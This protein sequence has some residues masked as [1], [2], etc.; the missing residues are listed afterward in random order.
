MRRS[1]GQWLKSGRLQLEAPLGEGAFGE[2]W[3][4]VEYIGFGQGGELVRLREAAVKCLPPL[5]D[6]KEGPRVVQEAQGL[7]ELQHESILRLYDAFSDSEGAYLI[8]ELA[9]EGHLWEYFGGSIPSENEL[10]ELLFAVARGL[11]YLHERGYIHGDLKPEN[12][13]VSAGPDYQPRFLIADFGLRA[14]IGSQRFQGTAPYI[15]PEAYRGEDRAFTDRSD[16][17]ALGI[18]LYEIA[19]G[20]RAADQLS[21]DEFNALR[22]KNPDPIKLQNALERLHNAAND[23]NWKSLQLPAF[24]APLLNFCLDPDPNRRPSAWG[25]MELWAAFSR[26]QS[27]AVQI[28]RRRT[29]ARPATYKA[30]FAKIIDIERNVDN[31]YGAETIAAKLAGEDGETIAVHI[32]RSVNLPMF[33][34]VERLQER[35]PE[36]PPAASFYNLASQNPDRMIFAAAKDSYAVIEPFHLVDVTD[37]SRGAFC[38]RASLHRIAG[39]DADFNEPMMRGQ[40]VHLLFAEYLLNDQ[41]DFEKAWARHRPDWNLH[42]AYLFEN[43]ER[44]DAF[45]QEIQRHFENL[46]QALREEPLLYS[47]R[48]HVESMRWSAELGLSGRVDAFFLAEG[49]RA[50]AYDLKTGRVRSS[51]DLIQLQAYAAILNEEMKPVND[52]Q[53][54]TASLR[55]RLISSADGN[56][57]TISPAPKAKI[58]SERNRTARLKETLMQPRRA[59]DPL[60]A[61]YPFFRYNHSKCSHCANHYR[62]L[63]SACEKTTALFGERTDLEPKPL[64]PLE[65]DYFWHGVRVSLIEE[66]AMRKRYLLPLLNAVY[67]PGNETLIETPRGER[68]I[69]QASIA[70]REDSRIEFEF[71]PSMN[72]FNIGDDAVI[73]RGDLRRWHETMRGTVVDAGVGTLAL[74]IHAAKTNRGAVNLP[75]HGWTI[76]RFPQFYRSDMVRRALHAFVSSNNEPMKELVLKGRMP[77]A[78]GELFSASNE[79]LRLPMGEKLNAQQRKALLSGLDE[80]GFLSIT[81]PPGT[82]KTMTIHAIID[83][84]IQHNATVLA[85]AVT[86]NAIDNILE[87]WIDASEELKPFFRFGTRSAMIDKFQALLNEKGADGRKYFAQDAGKAFDDIALL[88]K[89]IQDA[90]L[91]LGTAHSILE[92]PWIVRGGRAEPP[93]DLVI[94]DEATQM[95]EPLAAALL[96][97]GKKAILVGDEEQLG[98]ISLSAFDPER[99]DMP[100]TLQEIGVAGLDKSLFE[101]LNALFRKRE[102]EEGMVFLSRQYRMHPAISQWASEQFYGGKLETADEAKERIPELENAAKQPGWDILARILDPEHPFV[103]LDIDDGSGESGSLPNMNPAEAE[104]AALLTRALHTLGMDDVGCITPYRHQHTLL[105]QKLDEMNLNAECGTVDA[106]QGREKTVIILSTARRDRLT[107]FLAERRRLNVSVT[108][109]R[110]KCVILGS[111]A[112]LRDHPLIWKLAQSPQCIRERVSAQQL[113]RELGLPDMKENA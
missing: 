113:R 34:A 26:S 59:E 90:P 83:A 64:T 88:R 24:L 94:V 103:F 27:G 112:V 63:Y 87:R 38:Q 91:I 4:A 58:V 86:N 18:L 7:A 77:K 15:P 11:S 53:R 96:T 75:Q 45:K 102:E 56:A 50:A 13:L 80:N 89:Q 31:P 98:P 51:S 97:L 66:E 17:Y 110:R 104:I 108:R 57:Q 32:D 68:R 23:A 42:L 72:E 9:T 25:V 54:E 61:D 106:F 79:P 92:S 48:R 105:R 8:T 2:V 74:E 100:Q 60:P 49:G 43:E 78:Q 10:R 62:Y 28:D 22:M 6:E 95:Q 71:P 35:L 41:T 99:A 36:S 21:D 107:A 39:T 69:E 3:K 19:S 16:V 5:H 30:P 1:P 111:A 46:K 81:G 29:P 76:D 20:T 73:H 47:P 52:E 37:L 82:G 67:T 84:Y 65:R 70:K 55:A 40:I 93:F 101:R 33:N 12:I 14:L 44:I 109:A 85:A